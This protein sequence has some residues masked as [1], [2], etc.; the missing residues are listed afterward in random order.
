VRSSS[1]CDEMAVGSELRRAR[2]NSTGSLVANEEN[3]A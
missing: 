2:R 1:Y 3:A